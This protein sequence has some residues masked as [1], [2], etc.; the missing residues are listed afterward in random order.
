MDVF[1]YVK[2]IFSFLVSNSLSEVTYLYDGIKM[3]KEEF[4][5]LA[6]KVADGLANAEELSLYTAGYESYQQDPEICAELSKD[7]DQLKKHSL[8]AVWAQIKFDPPASSTLST[9]IQSIAL[10]NSGKKSHRSKWIFTAAAIATIVL[11]FWFFSYR[12]SSLPGTFHDKNW[13]KSDIGPGSSGATITLANGKVIPLSEAKNGVII[14]GSSLTYND[15]S[16]IASDNDRQVGNIIA[17]TTK[18]QTYQLT[19]PDGSNVWLNAATTLK[20]PSTFTN[21]KFREVELDGEA[22]FEIFKNKSQPFVVRTK[23]NGSL[24]VQE[25]KVLGTHFNVNAYADE[26]QITT[27]LQ[28]G[29]VQVFAQGF[30]TR[31]LKPNQQARLTAEQLDVAE[32]NAANAMAWKNGELKFDDES[33]GSIM[34]KIS[35]W[36][37]VEV[38][39]EGTAADQTFWGTISRFQ[40]VSKVLENLEL[41][42]TVNFRIEGRKI[43]VYQLNQTNKN[44]K[45]NLRQRE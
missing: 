3:N 4:I 7:V 1:L 14:S 2:K 39:Y 21:K 41:T 34:R 29:S 32:A 27:D 8:T 33:L 24:P 22:Y 28:E 40:N 13:V 25:I 9:P 42:S 20:F 31:V 30:S 23:A 19:L 10:E 45:R 12:T 18:G 36:Y 35:R 11:G 43:I 37:N 17:N 26:R 44:M 16:H 6:G 38:I 5:I 15:G